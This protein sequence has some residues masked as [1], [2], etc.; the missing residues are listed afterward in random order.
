MP[1]E[2]EIIQTGEKAILIAHHKKTPLRKMISKLG[3]SGLKIQN[4]NPDNVISIGK[5]DRIFDNEAVTIY[6]WEK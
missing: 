3:I 1:A 6:R 5:I 2:D 4:Y